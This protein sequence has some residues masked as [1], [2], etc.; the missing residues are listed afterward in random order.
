LLQ[1][2]A[3]RRLLSEL[4]GIREVINLYPKKRKSSHPPRQTVLTRMSPTRQQRLVEIL[5]LER[6]KHHELG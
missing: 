5:G 6:E 3:L 1:E 2:Q 4:D